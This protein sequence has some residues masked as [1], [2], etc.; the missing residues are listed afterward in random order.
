MNNINNNNN[1]SNISFLSRF[2]K[3]GKP[4]NKYNIRINSEELIKNLS[5]ELSPKSL[6]TKKILSSF[7]NLKN[8]SND[9]PNN[10]DY[11]ISIFSTLNK[12][13]KRLNNLSP[14]IFL[15][16]NTNKESNSIR[17]AYNSPKNYY[18]QD[19]ILDSKEEKIYLSPKNDS[20]INNNEKN[21]NN[22]KKDNLNIISKLSKF[23]TELINLQKENENLKIENEEFKEIIKNLKEEFKHIKDR[24][25]NNEK[26]IEQEKTIKNLNSFLER[27]EKDFNEEKMRILFELNEQ[28][29]ENEK[30]HQKLNN[31]D[32]WKLD[33]YEDYKNQ[34][35]SQL[36]QLKIKDEQ[37]ESLQEQIYLL[38]NLGGNNTIPSDPNES[39]DN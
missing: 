2:Q 17:S 13:K 14:K 34:F 7:H 24:S 10:S 39:L 30:L 5:L 9:S 27:Q 38:S 19:L 29:K 3:I 32:K 21:V 18:L 28:I 12:R 33:Y 6:N 11:K 25:R 26:I 36:K 22:N 37:I 4:R 23:K 8:N 35:K 1:N 31:S 16:D 15:E 20:L